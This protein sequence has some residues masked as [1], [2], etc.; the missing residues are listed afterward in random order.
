M[1]KLRKRAGGGCVGEFLEFVHTD[2][3]YASAG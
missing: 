2:G 1:A 3:Y